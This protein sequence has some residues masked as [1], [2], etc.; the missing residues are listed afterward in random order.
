M[1]FKVLIK[2]K[3]FKLYSIFLKAS[4]FQQESVKMSHL[5]IKSNH[6]VYLDIFF[7]LIQ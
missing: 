3:Y 1:A 2:N 5:I 7:L 6:A 4:K